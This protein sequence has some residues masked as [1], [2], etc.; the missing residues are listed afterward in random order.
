[1]GALKARP[2]V[3]RGREGYTATMNITSVVL[4]VLGKD[5]PGLVESLAKTIEQHG[6][7]WVESRFG[8]LAGQFAGV[9][10]VDLPSE[11]V[12][13]LEEAAS[14]LQGQGLRVAVAAVDGPS[15]GDEPGVTLKLELVGHDRP[16]IVHE[17]A[18][19]LAAEGVNVTSLETDQ[20]SAPMSGEPLFKAAAWL[21]VPSN[22]RV[23]AVRE[24]LERVAEA[25]DLDLEL[26]E[27]PADQAL[28]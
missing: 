26:D 3:L 4:T 16:G 8:R 22:R 20:V 9:V 5:R 21:A 10:R 18:R 1:M 12:A 25:L 14:G 17:V 7:N 24:G 23:D 6:G 15:V 19:A 13:G 2:G 27:A 28:A 11:R